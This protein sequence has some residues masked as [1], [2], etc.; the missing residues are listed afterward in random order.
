[1]NRIMMGLIDLFGDVA[2]NRHHR[3]AGASAREIGHQVAK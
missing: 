2:R 3:D 1:M